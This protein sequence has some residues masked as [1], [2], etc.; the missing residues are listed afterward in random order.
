[1]PGAARD[2]PEERVF[3]VLR[4]YPTDLQRRFDDTVAL[5]ERYD[6][7]DPYGPD[8]V[9]FRV[10]LRVFTYGN[11]L[12][13]EHDGRFSEP[14][15]DNPEQREIYLNVGFVCFLNSGRNECEQIVLLAHSDR[16]AFADDPIPEYPTYQSEEIHPETL[17]LKFERK[18]NA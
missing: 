16:R 12:E 2:H 6:C 17:G 15:R 8:E 1:M 13:P 10:H 11:G 9:T 14:S 3:F 18:N 7:E 4:F 5:F